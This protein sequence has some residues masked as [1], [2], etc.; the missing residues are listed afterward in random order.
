MKKL[1][2]LLSML[3]MITFMACDEKDDFEDLIDEEIPEEPAQQQQPQQQQQQQMQQQQ[4][5]Q[6]QMPPPAQPGEPIKYFLKDQ[7]EHCYLVYVP[8]FVDRSDTDETPKRS[9]LVM[10]EDGKELGPAHS[11]H[12]DIRS[13]GKGRFSHYQA[14][15]FFSTSDNTDPRQNGKTYTFEFK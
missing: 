7:G 8:Q 4:Q 9:T 15:I 3:L 12:K 6:R 14:W 11:L 2:L 10:Y 5:G 1:L 13:K